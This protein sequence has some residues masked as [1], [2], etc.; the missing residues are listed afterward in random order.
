MIDEVLTNWTIEAGSPVF[1][2]GEEALVIELMEDMP[3]TLRELDTEP[4]LGLAEEE[5]ECWSPTVTKDILRKLKDKEIKRQEHI[6]EFILTEKHHC[7]TLR[8]MQ[9]VNF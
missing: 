2:Y 3:M 8:V 4:L 5:S 7:L 6:Y 1:R 9:K